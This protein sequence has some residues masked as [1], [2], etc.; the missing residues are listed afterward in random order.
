M[1]AKTGPRNPVANDST[2]NVPLPPK[3]QKAARKV[4]APDENALP[5]RARKSPKRQSQMAA[6]N[7]QF[8]PDSWHDS[9][10]VTSTAGGALS[11]EMFHAPSGTGGNVGFGSNAMGSRFGYYSNLVLRRIGEKWNT[12]GA[13]QLATPAIVTFDILRS[14]Q[15]KNIK[16]YQSSGNPALDN[17]ALRAVYEASPFDP[18][19]GGFSGS[20]VDVE[21]WFYVKK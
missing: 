21:L 7:Q 15:T 19:P 1:P 14:G 17:S 3:A 12:A 5:I 9:N 8:R 20:Q 11:S 18:L 4:A 16:I 10:K 13:P 6:S 2:S